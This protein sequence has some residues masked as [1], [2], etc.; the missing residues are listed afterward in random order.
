MS[1]RREEEEAG[2]ACEHCSSTTTR[3]H[4]HYRDTPGPFDLLFTS[5]GLTFL[6]SVRSQPPTHPPSHHSV[7]C[8]TLPYTCNWVRPQDGPEITDTYAHNVDVK[9]NHEAL[10]LHQPTLNEGASV[11]SEDRDLS[12]PLSPRSAVYG[13]GEDASQ[14]QTTGSQYSSGGPQPTSPTGSASGSRWVLAPRRVHAALNSGVKS[15]SENNK[16]IMVAW[17]GDIRGPSG[18]KMGLDQLKD[19][20]K[21]ELEEGLADI[22]GKDEETGVTCVPVW[23]PDK[24]SV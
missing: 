19:Q 7:V 20:Q 12:K 4:R 18:E 10:S 21:R 8:H 1:E 9:P 22:S 14:H 23:M 11:P 16:V 6:P 17:P 3:Q 13:T 2:L 15:L 24:V 5:P